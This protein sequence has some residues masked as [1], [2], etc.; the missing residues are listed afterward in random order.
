MHK[1]LSH[2]KIAGR[3]G[4][5]VIDEEWLLKHWSSLFLQIKISFQQFFLVHYSVNT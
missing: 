3:K 2:I 1:A 5:T 4:V